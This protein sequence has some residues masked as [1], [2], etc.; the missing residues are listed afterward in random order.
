MLGTILQVALGRD[1]LN[2]VVLSACKARNLD[3]P[4][5]VGRVGSD[6]LAVAIIDLELCAGEIGLLVGCVRLDEVERAASGGGR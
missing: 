5:F 4:L 6:Q 1:G 2:G 3:L